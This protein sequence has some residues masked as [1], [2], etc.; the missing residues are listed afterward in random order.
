MVLCGDVP[1]LRVET[2]RELLRRHQEGK[3][4]CTILTARVEDPYGYGRIKRQGEDV[5]DIVEEL[6][7]TES[8]RRIREIN[9]GV[10]IFHA[11]DLFPALENVKVNSRKKE[12][13]LTDVVGILAS[14]KKK[15]G[16]YE[17]PFP[18]E[19]LGINTQDDFRR[20]EE[21]LQGSIR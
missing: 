21:L 17:T 2:L 14:G 10:Y 12:Y 20:A 6:N 19:I 8:E 11:S 18:G 9:S 7:A 13:Y 16:T 15:I 3:N 5:V 4:A 1:F